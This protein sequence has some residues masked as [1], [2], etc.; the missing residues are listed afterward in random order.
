MAY[1]SSPALRNAADRLPSNIGRS[2]LVHSL[3]DSLDLFTQ[4]SDDNEGVNPLLLVRGRP[5]RATLIEPEPVTREELLTFHDGQ[6]IDAL[7]ACPEANDAADDASFSSQSIAIT[8]IGLRSPNGLQTGKARR[9]G[10]HE[11][12]DAFPERRKGQ[13]REDDDVY[14][15]EYDC[16][17]FPGVAEYISQVA[18]GSLMAARLLCDGRADIAVFWDGGRHHASRAQA[19]GFCYVNDVVLAILELQRAPAKRRDAGTTFER[20]RAAKRLK[21]IMYI[22]LDLHH[23]DGVAEAF[24]DNPN[25]ITLSLHL[26]SRGFYPSTPEGSLAFSGPPLPSPADCTSLN[27]AIPRSGFGNSNFLRLVDSCIRPIFDAHQPQALVV[28]CGLDGLAG[29]PCREFNLSLGGYGAAVEKILSWTATYQGRVPVLLLG[30]GGYNHAN[31]ARGWAQ[32]TAVALGRVGARDRLRE[33]VVPSDCEHWD[34]FAS[35]DGGD[36]LDVP[37]SS[38]RKDENSEDDIREIEQQFEEYARRL[39]QRKGPS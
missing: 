35:G 1:V 16:P 20:P 2:S 38:H 34:T 26:W 32:L 12:S 5:A 27:V 31:A 33:A 18:G 39:R 9:T 28:Q 3:I 6:F 22:D 21:K 17:L 15:I 37:A 30:G 11:N 4:A 36:G 19:S 23:G 7:L 29:D 25:V 14:G 24:E 8:D 13:D 10:H